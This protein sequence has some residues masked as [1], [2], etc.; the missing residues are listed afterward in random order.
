MQTNLV[1]K[2]KHIYKS[3]AYILA[4]VG[5]IITTLVLIFSLLTKFAPLLNGDERFQGF[6]AI[7]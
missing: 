6:F 5:L 1:A 7:I 2:R 3:H 4:W